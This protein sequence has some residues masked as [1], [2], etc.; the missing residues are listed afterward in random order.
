MILD[1]PTLMAME[2]FVFGCAGVI[3]LFAW[4]R[5][6]KE[7]A[8]A[9]WGLSDIFVAI[10]IFLLM[11]GGAL[12]K[13]YAIVVAGA[14]LACAQTL[15]W[16]AARVFDGRPGPVA[17][18]ILG[19]VLVI[20][21]GFTPVLHG[22]SASVGLGLSAG[23]LIATIVSLWPAAKSKLP[24]RWP[25]IGFVAVHATVL[26]IGAY[27]TWNGMIGDMM[28]PLLSSFGLIHFESIIFAVGTAVFVLALVNERSEAATRIAAG[29]DPLTGIANRAAFT[30]DASAIIGRCRREEAP[31]SVIMFDLD[32]FKAVNDTYGHAVGDAV[33]KKFCEV[34]TAAL[35][36]GDVFGRLGG[37]EFAV[38]L[39]W[40]SIEPACIRADRIRNGFAEV[41]RKVGDGHINPTVSGGVSVSASG[42][43]TLSELLADADEALYRAKAAGRN[44]IKRADQPVPD[45]GVSVIRVA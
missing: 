27:S 16:Q 37:E 40:S 28:P 43:A 15:Q 42:E 22:I 31:V 34:T 21:A 3:L 2:S 10:G 26:A 5:N 23:Y 36:P 7:P 6:R 4:G 33:I 35:R 13:P 25:I 8:L 1:V 17:L 14:V 20:V 41:C 9:L 29:I 39:P 24:A 19:P 11:L 12:Q 45:G 38:V 44:R 32:R 18:M 30:E